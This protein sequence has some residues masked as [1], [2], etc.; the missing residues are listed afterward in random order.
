MY[1]ESISSWILEIKSN[2]SS[3]TSLQRIIST[4]LGPNSC[5]NA[6]S[7]RHNEHDIKIMW[8]HRGKMGYFNGLLLNKTFKIEIIEN[9]TFVS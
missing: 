2:Y 5:V 6:G 1:F 8:T 4:N 7:S 3:Q 9:K